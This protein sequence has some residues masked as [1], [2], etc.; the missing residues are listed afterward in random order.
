VLGNDAPAA[1]INAA[2]AEGDLHALGKNGTI[3]FFAL[4]AG[5]PP[6]SRCRAARSRPRRATA[7]QAHPPSRRKGRGDWSDAPHT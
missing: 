4:S 3:L 1:A 2:E 6:R 5:R 7:S